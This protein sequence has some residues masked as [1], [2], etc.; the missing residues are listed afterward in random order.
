MPDMTGPIGGPSPRT[1]GERLFPDR[2][3]GDIRTIPTHVGRTR[4]S[5]RDA[6]LGADHPHARGE[7]AFEFH[8]ALPTNG[9]S[10]RTW[11]EL[12]IWPPGRTTSRTIPTH[13][14]RTGGRPS[15]VRSLTDHP[16]ARGENR[17]APLALLLRLGPSPRTC[18]E[19]VSVPALGC[20]PR[21]IPTHVGRTASKPLIL[22][23]V[24]DHPHARGENAHALHQDVR[25]AGPSPRTWGERH[26]RE[27]GREM[28]RTIPT[29]VGRTSAKFAACFTTTDHPHAR[30][31]NGFAA[32][33]FWHGFGPSPRTWG[34]HP[35]HDVLR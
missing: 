31:E 25:L 16:H 26:L 11:G 19:P 3:P 27:L 7:N 28:S 15:R 12:A 8:A 2:V 10:P 23:S 21:T 29:H 35:I 24:A 17:T 33:G 9:P 20:Q 18:G 32:H 13:V 30:G 1:W 4:R 34:E 5:R 22:P 6:D 14:G